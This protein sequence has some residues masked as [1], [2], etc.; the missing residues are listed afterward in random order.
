MKEVIKRRFED[1]QQVFTDAQIERI[2]LATAGSFRVFFRLIR[3]V[4][5]KV[6]EKNQLIEVPVADRFLERAENDF[7]RDMTFLLPTEDRLWLKK[8]DSSRKSETPK[9]TDKLVLMKFMDKD[10]VFLYHNGE[11]WFGINPLL[12]KALD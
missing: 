4:L 9:E 11:A 6:P 3:A 2:I 8:I 10:W 5:L 12:K 1:W 7:F